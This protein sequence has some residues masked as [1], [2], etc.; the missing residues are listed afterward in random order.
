MKK[1]KHILVQYRI[2]PYGVMSKEADLSK[3]KYKELYKNE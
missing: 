3:N 2:N 1:H